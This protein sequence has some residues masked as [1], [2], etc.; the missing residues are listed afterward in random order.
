MGSKTGVSSVLG[1]EVGE[2]LE[3]SANR[4]GSQEANSPT[5]KS[6]I[7]PVPQQT[8]ESVITVEKIP[9]SSPRVRLKE[10]TAQDPSCRYRH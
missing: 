6:E 10:Y 3:G 7:L 4:E 8:S 2:S 5:D 9:D 1:E